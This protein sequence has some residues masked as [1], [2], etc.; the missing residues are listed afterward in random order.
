MQGHNHRVYDITSLQNPHIKEDRRLRDR[1]RRDES[2]LMAVE[3]YSE[4]SLL[5]EAGFVPERLYICPDLIKDREIGSLEL[6][7][8]RG[9]R[10]IRIPREIMEKLSYRSNP[11]A[12]FCV[13][14][15][16]PTDLARLPGPDES[17]GLYII[18]EDLEKPGNLGA[19]LRSA[20]AAGA[21]GV[22]VSDG[23]TDLGNPNVVRASKGV[24]F[25]FP[26]AEA[27]N[28]STWEWLSERNIPAAIADPVDTAGIWESE[29]PNPLAVVLGAENEGVSGFWRERAR[30][31]LSIPMVGRVNSL[32]VAQAGT[33]IMYELL[34][35]RH[36]ENPRRSR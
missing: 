5:L 35:R 7:E 16:P 9:I 19:I 25:L 4:V 33:L 20:D 8:T 22:I 6:F 23:R 36:M 12:W 29:L 11:D 3:G 26:C 15:K 1:R 17:S 34:R 14:A 21:A 30:I 2:G 24:N 27:D 32:N 31:R 28:Q 10:M 13:A 18:C